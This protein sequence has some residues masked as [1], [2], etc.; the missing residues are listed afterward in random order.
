MLLKIGMTEEEITA[1]KIYRPV[2]CIECLRGF[3]GRTAIHEI[4]YLT[5]EIR[6][7]ILNSGLSINETAIRRIATD[8]GM[9]TLREAAIE[10]LKRG[11]TSVQEVVETTLIA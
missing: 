3:K 7:Y 10:L 5:K 4:L 1:T 9:K 2:G 8:Q 6:E 11:T